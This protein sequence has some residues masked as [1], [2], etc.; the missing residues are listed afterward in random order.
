MFKKIASVVVFALIV[1]AFIVT[2]PVT[3]AIAAES[4]VVSIPITVTAAPAD[5]TSNHVSVTIDDPALAN[6][7]YTLVVTNNETGGIVLSDTRVVNTHGYSH[8]NIAE[9]LVEGTELGYE[10]VLVVN[11]EVSTLTLDNAEVY[12]SKIELSNGALVIK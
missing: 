12:G 3:P 5:M 6:M 1:L 11:N 8:T 7:D 10:L 9:S 4:G 2:R